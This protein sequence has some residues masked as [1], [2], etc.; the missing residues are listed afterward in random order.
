MGQQWAFW[1]SWKC[2]PKENL[3]RPSLISRFHKMKSDLKIMRDSKSCLS[4]TRK[5]WS[6]G[7]LQPSIH[8]PQLRQILTNSKSVNLQWSC[9]TECK[10]NSK[11]TIKWPSRNL[12]KTREATECCRESPLSSVSIGGGSNV[13][14]PWLF[15]IHIWTFAKSH[16]NS[17]FWIF[18]D[19]WWK[20][21]RS[22]TRI[23]K[24][25]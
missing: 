4:S 15:H 21:N 24:R 20:E 16:R 7:I 17:T 3:G 25:Q 8:Q 9:L 11:I 5:P 22:L 12:T 6:S 19:K 1:Q 14:C 18:T 13:S 23:K 2:W 10:I